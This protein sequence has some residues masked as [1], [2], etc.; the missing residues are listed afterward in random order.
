MQV[1]FVFIVNAMMKL[2]LVSTL[3]AHC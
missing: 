1:V 2:S 3:V